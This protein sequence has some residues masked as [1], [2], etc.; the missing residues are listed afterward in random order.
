M[1]VSRIKT[2]IQICFAPL[3]AHDRSDKAINHTAGTP[4]QRIATLDATPRQDLDLSKLSTEQLET[5]SK[6]LELAQ[7][8]KP[9]VHTPP[10]PEPT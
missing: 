2:T 4:I 5:L 7:P 3:Y 8:G 9:A 10:L 1:I 6:L